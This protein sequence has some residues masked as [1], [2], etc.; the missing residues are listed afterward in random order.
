[1]PS[2]AKKAEQ[3]RRGGAARQSDVIRKAR[4]GE[5]LGKLL[6]GAQTLRP[7]GYCL[8]LRDHRFM[9]FQR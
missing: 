7:L 4:H 8:E 1:M 5:A 6:F 2:S 9:R 3:I